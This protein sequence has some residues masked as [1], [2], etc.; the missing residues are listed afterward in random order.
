MLPPPRLMGRQGVPTQMPE[1]LG[2]TREILNMAMLAAANPLK[3]ESVDTA[4]GKNSLQYFATWACKY[5]TQTIQYPVKDI[6]TVSIT[7]SNSVLERSCVGCNQK[8]RLSPFKFLAIS[9]NKI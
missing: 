3:P 5:D 1:A 6:S 7:S 9:F 8:S 4:L 2:Y